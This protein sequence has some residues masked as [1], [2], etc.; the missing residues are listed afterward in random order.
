MSTTH[1]FTNVA[2]MIEFKHAL[3]QGSAETMQ[4]GEAASQ[5]ATK[6]GDLVYLA[7]GLA[8][9]MADDG[10]L[11]WGIAMEDCTGT[12]SNLINVLVVRPGDVFEVSASTAFLTVANVGIKYALVPTAAGLWQLVSGDV[13]DPLVVVTKVISTTRALVTFMPTVLQYLVGA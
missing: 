13:T 10:Q 1:T 7:S 12:T 11:L 8:H 4:I 2:G 9:I 6:A 5:S 3:N